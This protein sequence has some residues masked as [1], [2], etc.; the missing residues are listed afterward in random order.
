MTSRKI[1][2]SAVENLVSDLEGKANVSN[3]VTTDTAQTISS[4]KRFT[5]PAA[6]MSIELVADTNQQTVPAENT[7]RVL[8]LYCNTTHTKGDGYSAWVAGYRDANGIT[9]AILSARKFLESDSQAIDNYINISVLPDGTPVSYTKTPP[10]FCAGEEIVTAGWVRNACLF[11]GE[12]IIW[13]ASNPPAGYLI[14]DGAAI[15]RTTYASLFNVIGTTWGAGDG[16]TTFNLPN[17]VD[18]IPQGS[19]SRGTVGAYLAESL[20]NIRGR[21]ANWAQNGRGVLQEGAL[22]GNG[23]SGAGGQAQGSNNTAMALD[24]SRYS[25]IYQDNAPV[26]QAATAVVFCIRY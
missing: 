11:P 23:T 20:P 3:T 6:G 9:S 2:E 24:A 15:S 26:Q 22:Y 4:S 12:I 19:G 7:S 10:A 17:F 8:G 14:C 13:S 16:N 25:S 21:F 1:P 5:T 18:R